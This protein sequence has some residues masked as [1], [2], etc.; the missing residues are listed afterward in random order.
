[1]SSRSAVQIVQ[2][3]DEENNIF[4]LN[5]TPIENIL[6]RDD[7]KD[8]SLVIISIAGPVR[9]GKS[10]ILNFFLCYMNSKVCISILYDRKK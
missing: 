2:M 7:V 3:D 9:G 10:F 8:R 5:T 1:M 6:Y 4:S